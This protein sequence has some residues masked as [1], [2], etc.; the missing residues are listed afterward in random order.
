MAAQYRRQS[1]LSAKPME[2]SYKL[3]GDPYPR[4]STR[5]ESK[6]ASC[7]TASARYRQAWQSIFAKALRTGRVPCYRSANIGLPARAVGSNGWRHRSM[8]TSLSLRRARAEPELLCPFELCAESPL[9]D[10]RVDLSAALSGYIDS[11]S[12]I[13]SRPA[14]HGRRRRKTNRI[15]LQCR[16]PLRPYDH[17][18]N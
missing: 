7:R 9:P 18:S 14:R 5:H 2:D 13:T 17:S 3:A 16:Q 6:G 1:V 10:G 15:G 12:A 8:A 4:L 11:G